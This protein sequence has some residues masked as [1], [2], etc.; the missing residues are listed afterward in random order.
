MLFVFEP[1]H[2]IVYMSNCT[3]VGNYWVRADRWILENLTLLS[4]GMSF[5]EI[6]KELIF[7]E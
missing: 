1:T 3:V 7:N 5:M 4:V 6:L 2:K